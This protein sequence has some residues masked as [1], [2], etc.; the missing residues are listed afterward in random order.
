MRLFYLVTALGLLVS[1]AAV[2]GGVEHGGATSGG[3]VSGG[4]AP[5]GVTPASG[6]AADAAIG[7]ATP[8]GAASGSATS[9]R[10]AS[11]RAEWD[12]AGL[13]RAKSDRAG[14]DRVGVDRVGVDRGGLDRAGSD[15]AGAGHAESAGSGHVGSAGSAH[16]AS[17]DITAPVGAA[18]S[19]TM[20]PPDPTAPPTA[21]AANPP[22]RNTPHIVIAGGMTRPVFSYQDAI[23]ETVYVDT[24]VD[25]D[26]DGEHDRVAVYVTRPKETGHGL[27]VASIIEASPY[28]GGTV[29]TPYHPADVTD[30]P[31]LAPWQPP[32]APWTPPDHTFV[33]YDNYFVSRGYAVLAAS[34]LGTGESTGCPGAVSPE[35]TTAMKTVVEWLTGKATAHTADGRK[36]EAGW[37]TKNVAMA[38]KSYD[39]TLPLATAATGVEGLKTIVSIS[40]VGS[41]YDYY[42]ANGG[43]VAPAGYE[44]EDAD[45]HAEVVLTR[46]NPA[47]CAPEMRRLEKDMDRT[48]GDYN[49]FWA[50]RNFIAKARNLRASVLVTGGLNDWNVKP[51]QFLDL[52]Q[53]LGRAGVPR[54]L[55]IHQARHDD[56]I[57]V[58]QQ[59]WLDT[60][61]RWFA[62]W[63]Y[64]V[65]NGIMS[66][67]KVD[68]ERA[69]GQWTTAPD[70]PDPK[71]RTVTLSLNGRRGFVDAPSRTAE[72]LTERPDRPD[73]NRLIYLT[74]KLTAPARLSGTPKVRLKAA[75]DGSSPYLTALLVDYG[76]DTRFAG[77]SA[78][79]Q[80]WCFGDSVPGDSGC[81][82]VRRYVTRRT[83]Y[84]IVTRGW[85]DVRNRRSASLTEEIEKGRTYAFGWPL[86]P[87]DHV[88]K[89][90]H[91][92]GLVIMAT[93]HE[94]TLRYPA[95]TKVTVTGGE[96]DLPLDGWAP[97]RGYGG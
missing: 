24:P 54:K 48:S 15:R 23:R 46:K 27:K 28:Y 80:R 78:T 97:T 79:G 90:G 65:E 39:G 31:R 70:W 94:Y 21:P 51:D 88:F 93:D 74:P 66:E 45:L 62:H 92:I 85:L 75:V 59:V 30:R 57:D 61:D 55:W 16:A 56:P 50:A 86:V 38:G 3:T 19:G 34:T 12:R 2:P 10:G 7:N 64:G 4:T 89:P 44:G 68:L 5:A 91:R 9:D 6:E 81:R 63:L 14:L 87:Y 95:G 26:H 37:S 67:P 83:P 69:P 13:D 20:T 8:A 52:W 18:P 72:Q 73:P 11:D 22:P 40:G 53:A 76:E 35:E 25:S 17:A 29:N 84:E 36:A 32:T 42:R 96:L 47:V 82:T 1:P 33:Y 77:F 41:W 58:R 43:V 60:L 49:Q 71:A